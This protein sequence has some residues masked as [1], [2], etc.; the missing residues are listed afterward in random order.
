M[1]CTGDDALVHGGFTSSPSG[2]TTQAFGIATFSF[3]YFL[4]L[5]QR[6]A[7][8]AGEKRVEHTCNGF[9]KRELRGVLF[10]ILLTL[11]LY[12][13]FWVGAT[14]VHDYR[15]HVGDVALGVFAGGISSTIVMLRTIQYYDR[16]YKLV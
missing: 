11:P 13:A 5:Y 2:H 16:F 14:R 12:G 15:H 1:T 8:E 6:T 7:R 10:F 4:W 9:V 3:I